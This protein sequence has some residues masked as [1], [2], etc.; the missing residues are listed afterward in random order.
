VKASKIHNY[1]DKNARRKPTNLLPALVAVGGACS[2]AALPATALELGD[3]RVNS[4]L[5]QPLRASIAYALNPTEQIYN[6]C[7]Y[8]HSG[9]S[10][11]SS[12][13][14]S[15]ARI[16]VTDSA[17]LIT[18]ST[19]VREPIV[20]VRVA[21]DCA[22]TPH[23]SREYTMLIDPVTSP[24]A[25]QSSAARISTPNVTTQDMTAPRT[26][27]PPV[28]A[29]E[30][31]TQVSVAQSIKQPSIAMNSRYRVQPGDTVST[32]VARI[33]DRNISMWSAVDIL[34]VA[35]P[36]A[37]V[38]QDVNRLLAGS[39]L[40]IPNLIDNPT[41]VAKPAFTPPSVDAD[42]SG[43]ITQAN[44]ASVATEPAVVTSPGV[45]IE[46]SNAANDEL[47]DEPLIAETPV[48]DE[49]TV[50]TEQASP[51]RP[52]DVVMAPVGSG[53]TNTAI[54]DTAND[55]QPATVPVVSSPAV[56][57]TR[58][59]GAWN[60]LLWLGGT[61]IALILG[62][63][64]FGRTLRER[65]GPT[66]AGVPAT[67]SKESDNDE[68]QKSPVLKDVDFEFEDTINSQAISLDADLEAGT[69]L[70]AESIMEVEVTQDFGFF[71]AGQDQTELDLEL[72]GDTASESESSPTDIIPPSHRDELSSILEKEDL[73]N[74]AD[75][76]DYDMSMIVDATKQRI[77]EY[78]ATAKDLQAVQIDADH[79]GDKF[80]N[81]VNDA[82][83]FGALEQ[84]YE[85]EL[86]ATQVLNA[87][88]EKAA[89][90]LA[91][92]MEDD[93]QN[94][95]TTEMPAVETGP[96]EAVV[97]DIV[98]SD[99]TAE[100]PKVDVE[101][102]AAVEL[103]NV[104]SSDDTAEL[105]TNLLT[106]IDADNDAEAESGGAEITVEMSAAGSD[107]TIEMQVESGSVD[108]K[109]K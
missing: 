49:T 34:F 88:I 73:P 9:S 43:A 108:T 66:A 52:G 97:L 90:D 12:P 105:T 96:G 76:G 40:I 11:G 70:N 1:K 18:G 93:E 50:A 86:T 102:E 24:A 82:T 65:F 38:D 8:L 7:I 41:A 27:R 31:A 69:G 33:E 37:F 91:T 23:L 85:D 42:Q 30:Q 48:S 56:D 63:L 53:T 55:N 5:G 4:A 103:R 10:G 25:T 39:N 45:S 106:S 78:D 83:D 15:N 46:G 21:V 16:S 62:L 6:Y 58:T 57:G 19:P 67:R 107:V 94:D 32:I 89:A 98:R 71:T 87:E 47:I 17:I 28:S 51:L 72:G 14:L 79:D 54:P 68:T 64:L 109:K 29:Q 80:E 44:G 59:T 35:N 22:Y 95:A 100:L 61:G 84:D 99:R 81:T 3:I 2:L 13:E 20:S 75:D 101:V 92:R 36:A 74:N 60:W 104:S 26:S 77:G